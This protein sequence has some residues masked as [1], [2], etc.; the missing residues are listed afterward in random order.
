MTAPYWFPDWSGKPA[1][2]VGTG[3]S[4]ADADLQICTDR[5]RMIVVNNAWQWKPDAD[6]LYA[7]DWQWWAYHAPHVGS[8]SGLRVR[9]SIPSTEEMARLKPSELFRSSQPYGV[10]CAA[11]RDAPLQWLSD[12]TANGGNS[13]FQAANLA[14]R[15]GA[16]RI[17][18]VGMDCDGPESHVKGGADGRPGRSVQGKGTIAAWLAAWRSSAPQFL[19]AGVDVINASGGSRIACF[20]KASLVDALDRQF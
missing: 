14:A 8:F 13:G 3:P 6:A 15:W 1:V 7:C 19:A 12:Y 17:I 16:K 11:K 9:G 4:L 2:I 10:R 20:R 5:A 18:L